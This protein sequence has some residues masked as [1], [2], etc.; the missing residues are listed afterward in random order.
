MRSINALRNKYVKLKK[1]VCVQFY[2]D[3]YAQVDL[4]M[5][6]FDPDFSIHKIIL[7]KTSPEIEV[8]VNLINDG[9]GNDFC[10]VIDTKIKKHLNQLNERFKKLKEECKT[11]YEEKVMDETSQAFEEWFYYNII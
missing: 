9:Y 8:L 6:G 2:K 7:K 3:I 1:M 10:D 5:S 4:Y 11:Y